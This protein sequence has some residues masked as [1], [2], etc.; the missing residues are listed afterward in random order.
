M[1]RELHSGAKNLIWINQKES[2]LGK[3]QKKKKINVKLDDKSKDRWCSRDCVS[4]WVPETGS[5][6][7]KERDV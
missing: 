4:P 3:V 2:N 7:A 1:E 6:E 5:P